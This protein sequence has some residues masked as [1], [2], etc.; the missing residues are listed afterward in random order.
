MLHIENGVAYVIGH[1]HYEVKDADVILVDARDAETVVAEFSTPLAA[2]EALARV[3]D[4]AHS[5]ANAV[6]ILNMEAAGSH[7]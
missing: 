5:V 4:E 1:G 2:D 7:A 3:R 6:A